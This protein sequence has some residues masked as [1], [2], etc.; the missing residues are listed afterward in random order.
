MLGM[1]PAVALWT[2]D[3]VFNQ[4]LGEGDEDLRKILPAWG[5]SPSLSFHAC[6][7]MALDQQQEL[8]KIRR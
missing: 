7:F 5:N 8:G 1:C 3:L 2:R 6:G 4:T